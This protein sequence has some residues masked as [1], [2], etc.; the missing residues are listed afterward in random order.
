MALAILAIIIQYTCAEAQAIRKNIDALTATE[1]ATYEHAIQLLKDK[2]AENPYLLDGYA[3]QAWVHNKNMVSVPENNTLTQGG[4]QEATDFYEI[5]ASQSYP[6]G[7]KG[8]PGMCEH[9]KDIFFI[10]H[11]AQ[12]YY[13]ERILQ[14]SDPEGTILDSKGNKYPTKNLGVP[15]WNFTATPSG[16]KFP[17]AYENTS[18]VL[19]H[20]G[21]NTAV[22]QKDSAFTSP[23]LLADLLSN[24]DWPTFGGYANATNGGYGTFESQIHNPMHSTYIGGE[25]GTPSTAAYDP[26][27]FSFHSYIDYIFEAWIQKHGSQDITSLGYFLRAEQPTEFNLPGYDPGAGDRPNMGKCEL[28]LD[29]DNLGYSFQPGAKDSLYSDEAIAG[30]YK[31]KK[32]N[33]LIFGKSKESAY[34]KLYTAKAMIR[35]TAEIGKISSETVKISSTDQQNPYIYSF[36][37]ANPTKSYKIDVY[38]HPVKKKAKVTSSKFRKKYFVG[39]A[40]AWLDQN[41][42]HHGGAEHKL[43]IDLSKVLND[44]SKKNEGAE[45]TLT[46]NYTKL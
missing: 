38:M 43:N 22:D 7:S 4:G 40:S 15:F 35:P 20:S 12:F 45:Y 17:I 18:S 24:P 29:T 31:D 32:G 19:Y 3:W 11:R 26:I 39:L 33:D 42:M 27:F 5:A 9:G 2:S 34:Y 14:D 10:W 1:L 6:D 46:I 8:Y 37:E 21:R 44:I 30:L 28:Y 16:S 13:F 25:M 36:T 23:Y 41:H